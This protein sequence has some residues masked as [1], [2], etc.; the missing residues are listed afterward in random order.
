M[1]IAALGGAVLGAGVSLYGQERANIANKK[2]AREQ[3]AF[4]ERMSGSS[5]QRAVRDMKLAGI[6][7]MLAYAQGGASSP[8]GQTA[9]MED[10]G[11]PAVASAMG[12]K[13]LVAD[14]KLVEQ[15]TEATRQQGFKSMS[16]ALYT[17]T[18]DRILGAGVQ[19]G[20]GVTPYGVIKKGLDNDLSRQQILLTTAQRRAL[21]VSPFLSKFV[22]TENLRRSMDWF[23]TQRNKLRFT[24]PKGGWK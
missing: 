13:R 7:P 6:N 21:E 20:L 4:Q 19:V 24:K 16:D 3:M 15:Q 17:Q 22:G 8:S 18:Q 14:L 10:V 9:R 23:S 5:Y 1:A 12:M 2:L 11:G